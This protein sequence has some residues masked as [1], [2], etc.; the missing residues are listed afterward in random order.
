[1]HVHQGVIQK[2]EKSYIYIYSEYYLA[3]TIYPVHL[4]TRLVF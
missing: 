2:N 4:Q 1:V 3:G